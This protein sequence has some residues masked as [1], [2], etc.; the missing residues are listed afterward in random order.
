MADRL[1]P[2]MALPCEEIE[3]ADIT[4][5]RGTQP[6][7]DNQKREKNRDRSFTYWKGETNH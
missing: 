4:P 6:R 2:L 7:E 3:K 1:T 5:K